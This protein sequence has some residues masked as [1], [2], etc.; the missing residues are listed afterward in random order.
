[1]NA[2]VLEFRLPRWP[3]VLRIVE[4]YVGSKGLARRYVE[5]AARGEA[6]YLSIVREAFAR[7]HIKGGHAW[8]A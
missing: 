7:R 5:R 2:K 1:M 8:M 6:L 4:R 3:R